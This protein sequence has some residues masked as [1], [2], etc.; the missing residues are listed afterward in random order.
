MEICAL[1]TPPRL[2]ALA[3]VVFDIDAGQRVECVVPEGALS[4]EECRL[5]A[6]HAFGVRIAGVVGLFVTVRANR[7]ARGFFYVI[8]W[9]CERAPQIVCVLHCA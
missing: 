3:L 7:A 6:F 5:V 8:C 9:T 4:L 1:P 2:C